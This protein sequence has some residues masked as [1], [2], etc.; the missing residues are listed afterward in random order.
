MFGEATLPPSGGYVSPFFQ[1]AQG[2][3]ARLW[4]V[5]PSLTDLICFEVLQSLNGV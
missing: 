3:P 4:F 5:F 1:P 2:T